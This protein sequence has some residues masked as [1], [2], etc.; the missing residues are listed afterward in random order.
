[1]TT[2]EGTQRGRPPLS[3]GLRYAPALSA[4]P[5]P[6]PTVT[7]AHLGAAASSGAHYSS[8]HN[9]LSVREA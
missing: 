7:A 9:K 4:A 1:M 3:R 5:S 8:V 6:P 2:A